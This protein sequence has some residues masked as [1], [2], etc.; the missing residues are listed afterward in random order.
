MLLGVSGVIA[1]LGDT[2]FP[3]RT[4]AEGFA[5]DFDRASNIFVRLRMW[6]PF[7][8]VAVAAWVLWF[9]TSGTARRSCLVPGLLAAQTIAGGANL[10]LLAP[11]WIQIVHLLL[12]DA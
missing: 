5:Q 2:L 11:V 1:A 9:T 3:A 6:H 8:A 4:L 10:L 7:L 12:A